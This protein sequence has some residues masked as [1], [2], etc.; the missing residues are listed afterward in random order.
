MYRFP[1]TYTQLYSVLYAME[2]ELTDLG[3]GRTVMAFAAYPWRGGFSAVNWYNDLYDAIPKADRP[4]VVGLKYSSPGWMDLGVI[5]GVAASIK[6]MIIAVS[7]AGRHVNDTYTEIQKGIH[8]REI[9]RIKLGRLRRKAEIEHIEFIEESS[10]RIAKL[11]GFKDRRE[12]DKYTGSPLVTL[13]ML[14]SI[15]R[16]LRTLEVYENDGKAMIKEGKSIG[17]DD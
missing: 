10:D 3:E 7:D 11:I 13:K 12:I 14:L 1:H 2:Q 9:N 16:R 15:Y 5:G 6:K 8:D 4:L 17:K